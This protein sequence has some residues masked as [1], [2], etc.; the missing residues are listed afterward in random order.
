[1]CFESYRVAV[2]SKD[3]AASNRPVVEAATSLHLGEV[4]DKAATM[5]LVVVLA[6]VPLD[7]EKDPLMM[8]ERREDHSYYWCSRH[9]PSVPGV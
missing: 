8:E 5:V 7:I 2:S 9:T 1:M 4:E 6:K 3:T